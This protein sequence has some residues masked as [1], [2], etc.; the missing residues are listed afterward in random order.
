MASQS[1][2]QP[3]ALPTEHPSH[4]VLAGLVQHRDMW[5]SFGRYAAPTPAVDRLCHRFT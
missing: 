1:V 2:T 5:I 4:F 3:Q